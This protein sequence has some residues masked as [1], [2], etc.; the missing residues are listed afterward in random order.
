MYVEAPVLVIATGF[1]FTLPT[2]TEPPISESSGTVFSLTD[3]RPFPNFLI[4][5]FADAVETPNPLNATR[6]HAPESNARRL[7]S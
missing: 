5:A 4:S 7:I 2:P 3:K 6:A 1:P